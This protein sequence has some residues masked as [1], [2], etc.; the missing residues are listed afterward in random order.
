[1]SPEPGARSPGPEAG[2]GRG[3][4]CLAREADLE[5]R[6]TGNARGGQDP[7]SSTRD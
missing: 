3:L 1:M 7:V 5:W 2:A 4:G 6:W